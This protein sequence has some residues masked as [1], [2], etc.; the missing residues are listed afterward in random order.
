MQIIRERQFALYKGAKH[1]EK[2]TCPSSRAGDGTLPRRL[3]KRTGC[4]ARRRTRCRAHRGGRRSLY[5]R[6]LPARAARRARR[7]HAGLQG[8]TDR[9]SRR[10]GPICGAECGERHPDLRHDRQRLCFRRR[11][12]H[13]CERHPG[14]AGRRRCNGLHPHPRHRGHR[15]RRCAGYQRL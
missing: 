6:H 9:S 11:G 15:I 12:S 3:R 7:R 5:R 2:S 10:Q 1:H 8:C 14:A 4:H 13:S